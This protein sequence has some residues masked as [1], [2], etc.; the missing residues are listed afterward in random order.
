LSEDATLIP[1]SW[2]PEK[3]DEEE[4]LFT[5]GNLEHPQHVFLL[6]TL[7]ELLELENT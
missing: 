7:T 5:T 1:L 4:Q 3:D 6:R 2:M